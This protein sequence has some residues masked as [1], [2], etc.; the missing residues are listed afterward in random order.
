VCAP[1]DATPLDLWKKTDETDGGGVFLESRCLRINH[2]VLD[3]RTI[4]DAAMEVQADNISG[5]RTIYCERL[6]QHGWTPR[7]ALDLRPAT[8]APWQKP[9]QTGRY[10]L[11]EYFKSPKSTEIGLE[12]CLATVDSTAYSLDAE[13]ADWDHRN[14][15]VAVRGTR[16]CAGQILD[17]GEVVWTELIDF[18]TA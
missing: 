6:R 3:A 13:W 18:G 17:G 1:P 16:L 14:P 15:L 2:S 5:G 4:H 10:L 11:R 7:L 12:I 9:D 8:P